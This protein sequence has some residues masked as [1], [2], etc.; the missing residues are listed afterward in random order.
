MTDKYAFEWM[1]EM[2]LNVKNGLLYNINQGQEASIP[3]VVSIVS[4]EEDGHIWLE[5]NS[6][7]KNWEDELNIPVRVQFISE[8]NIIDIN[9]ISRFISFEQLPQTIQKNVSFSKPILLMKVYYGEIIPFV[10]TEYS[11]F[12]ILSKWFQFQSRRIPFLFNRRLFIFR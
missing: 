12:Q 9:G 2:V 7:L 8:K 6:K 3:L 4:V 5:L 11:P 10:D 1:R